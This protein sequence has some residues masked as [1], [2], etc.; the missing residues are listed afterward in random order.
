[1]KTSNERKERKNGMERFGQ[2]I[3]V[4]VI[5]QLKHII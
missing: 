5:A 4:I 2:E 3:I 1:M